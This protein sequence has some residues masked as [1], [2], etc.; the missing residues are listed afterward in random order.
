MVIF[1]E[2][3]QRVQ[4]ISL[5]RSRSGCP[6]PPAGPVLGGKSCCPPLRLPAPPSLHPPALA[7]FSMVGSDGSKKPIRAVK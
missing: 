5:A 6:S 3:L 1:L 4:Q 7:A 2:H